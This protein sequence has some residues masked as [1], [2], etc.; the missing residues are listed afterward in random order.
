MKGAK[1]Y[2]LVDREINGV[3]ADTPHPLH[4]LFNVQYMSETIYYL[5]FEEGRWRQGVSL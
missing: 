5:L 4:R 3:S 1:K 2:P